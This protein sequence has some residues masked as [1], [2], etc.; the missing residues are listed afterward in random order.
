MRG[1]RNVY[2]VQL[3]ASDAEEMASLVSRV[4]IQGTSAIISPVDGLLTWHDTQNNV[5]KDQEKPKG[6]RILLKERNLNSFG[7]ISVN[8]F[9]SY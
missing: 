2:D 4:P 5:K 8:P 6:K 3:K 9:P 7:I 1:I